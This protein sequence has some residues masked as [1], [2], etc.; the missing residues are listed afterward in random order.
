MALRPDTWCIEDTPDGWILRYRLLVA[1]NAP[2]Y[3]R[4]IQRLPDWLFTPRWMLLWTM[5]SFVPMYVSNITEGF[6]PWWVDLVLVGLAMS[7]VYNLQRVIRTNS[8]HSVVVQGHSIHLVQGIYS[9]ECLESLGL[10][11]RECSPGR[12]AL[13][14]SGQSIHQ[15]YLVGPP[16]L[17]QAKAHDLLECLQSRLQDPARWRQEGHRDQG[18]AAE[19]R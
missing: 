7:G 5:C 9:I 10:S 3:E 8:E 16:G 15:A 4:W 2:W 1:N 11:D 12:S 19:S 6:V 14:F 18:L 17:S 13:A